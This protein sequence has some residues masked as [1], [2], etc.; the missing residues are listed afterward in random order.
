MNPVKRIEVVLPQGAITDVVKDLD[1]LGLSGYTLIRDVL[2]RGERGLRAGI[3]L[4]AFQY[5][6]LLI[7]CAATQVDAI[8]QAVRPYLKRFGG[9]CLVSDAAWVIH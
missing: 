1:A 9:M 4:G 6:L 7:A 5:Q 8:V 2:G 3:D